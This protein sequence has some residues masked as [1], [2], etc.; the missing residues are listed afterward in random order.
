MSI[1]TIL[2]QFNNINNNNVPTD[3]VDNRAKLKLYAN[4]FQTLQCNY[5]DDFLSKL[6]NINEAKAGVDLLTYIDQMS[7]SQVE[8]V[9]NDCDKMYNEANIKLLN[10][11]LTEQGKHPDYDAISLVSSLNN[12]T[13]VEPEQESAPEQE[14][15]PQVPDIGLLITKLFAAFGR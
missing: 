13:P 15:A 3:T 10:L 9:V 11:M 5:S 8:S 2:S 4:I 6:F 1:S 7:D 14:P 12:P